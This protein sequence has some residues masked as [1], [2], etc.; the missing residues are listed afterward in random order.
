MD[1]LFIFLVIISFE[2]SVDTLSSEEK[3]NL[4]T[5]SESVK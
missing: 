3:K 2:F 4:M 1:T 5:T